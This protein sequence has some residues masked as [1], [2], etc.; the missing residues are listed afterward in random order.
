MPQLRRSCRQLHLLL[1]CVRMDRDRFEKS[2]TEA[3]KHFTDVFTAKIWARESSVFALTF[4][5]RVLPPLDRDTDE[6]APKWFKERVGEFQERIVDALVSAGIDREKALMVPV[7]PTGYHKST[8]QLPNPKELLDRP[9]WFIPFWYACR[10]SM[11]KD[12]LL[13]FH[14]KGQEEKLQKMPKENA[15]S[16]FKKKLF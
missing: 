3:I 15:Y 1:Y 13:S 11:Q 2:E 14:Y 7:I 6:E 9:D 8:R 4:A 10:K 12:A 5:N 16:L